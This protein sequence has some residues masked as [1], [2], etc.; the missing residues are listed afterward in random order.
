[1]QPSSNI[2]LFTPIN[3]NEINIIKRNEFFIFIFFFF[4]H[5]HKKKKKKNFNS[6]KKKCIFCKKRYIWFLNLGKKVNQRKDYICWFIKSSKNRKKK[7][8]IANSQ[9]N[10]H[11]FLRNRQKT[12]F[13]SDYRNKNLFY[14][15]LMNVEPIISNISSG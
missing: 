3:K 8:K 15:D 4:W 12:D 1:M 11:R 5:H 14:F 10:T 9:K 13:I 6:K 2:K 7:R